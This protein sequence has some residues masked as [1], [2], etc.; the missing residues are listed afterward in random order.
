MTG[1]DILS[2]MQ[3]HEPIVRILPPSAFSV[4]DVVEFIRAMNRHDCRDYHVSLQN[5]KLNFNEKANKYYIT[6]EVYSVSGNTA[7]GRRSYD[8]SNKA[9]FEHMTR[10]MGDFI[11]DKNLQSYVNE[12]KV[13]SE[14]VCILLEAPRA[15]VDQQTITVTFIFNGVQKTTW[16]PISQNI[17]K[18]DEIIC[19]NCG[20]SNWPSRRLCRK[21]GAPL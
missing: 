3:T 20:I 8:I 10:T 4:A 15:K 21:C 19:P 12:C 17:K 9:D 6:G 18:I 11:S 7:H 2:R 5:I 14:G 13:I 16:V 1:K